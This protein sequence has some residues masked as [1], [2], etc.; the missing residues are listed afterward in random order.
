MT[1]EEEMAHLKSIAYNRGYQDGQQHTHEYY[2]RMFAGQTSEELGGNVKDL[3]TRLGKYED[4]GY[5]LQ[6]YPSDHTIVIWFKGDQ[7]AALPDHAA[8][9]ETIETHIKRHQARLR[10]PAGVPL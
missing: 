6:F 3:Q 4:D 2:R 8:T 7:V 5:T 10:E 9:P 1:K